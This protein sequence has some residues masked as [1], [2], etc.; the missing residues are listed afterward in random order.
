MMSAFPD[1][2]SYICDFWSDHIPI[3]G[4][5]DFT[6]CSRQHTSGT[7][8]CCI[9]FEFLETC[10]VGQFWW[11]RHDL[12]TLSRHRWIPLAY[13]QQRWQLILLCS[14][15]QQ[16]VKNSCVIGDLR[17]HDSHGTY[18]MA[19]LLMLSGT[20]PIDTRHIV[21]AVGERSP[22]WGQMD[23]TFYVIWD[24]TPPAKVHHFRWKCLSHMLKYSYYFQW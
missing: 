18:V 9:L 24:K 5:T 6:L 22:P 4:G 1:N 19:L 2:Q 10:P 17:R 20:E 8:L 11:W 12:E 14:F 23:R 16:A 7:S 13:G 3:D 15:A 21:C